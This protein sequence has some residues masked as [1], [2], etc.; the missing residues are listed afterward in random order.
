MQAIPNSSAMD[1][2]AHGGG[3]AAR[4]LPWI[5][6]TEPAQV[7]R[8]IAELVG[9][10]TKIAGIVDRIDDARGSLRTTWSAGSASDGAVGKVGGTIALFGK[11]VK[12]VEALEAEIQG[13]ALALGLVQNAYRGVVSSVNPTVA[14]LL[15][16]I[17]T[18]PAATA[19]ATGTTSGLAAFVSGTKA[20]LDTIALVRLVAIVTQL[21][22]IAGDLE[23]LFGD[24]SKT[25]VAGSPALTAPGALPVAIGA[26]RA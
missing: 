12:A 15:S 18:R 13:V 1:V 9:H 10:I 20:T 25:S 11:I 17:H 3:P 19:L 5:V 22:T 8:Y 23:A 16:N 14:A 7:Q 26:P 6:G 24:G 2:A 4:V 21:V